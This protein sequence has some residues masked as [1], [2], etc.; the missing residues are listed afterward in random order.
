MLCTARDERRGEESERES[1]PRA[2]RMRDRRRKAF[3][4]MGMENL[5]GGALACEVAT[6]ISIMDSLK[7]IQ[8]L[9]SPRENGTANGGGEQTLSVRSYGRCIIIAPTASLPSPPPS[10][11]LRRPPPRALSPLIQLHFIHNVPACGSVQSRVR[12]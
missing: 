11:P 4:A 12:R 9:G 2:A 8:N 5:P 10:S 3:G 1:G 6:T 7:C